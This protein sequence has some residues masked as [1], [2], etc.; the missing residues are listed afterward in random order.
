MNG[1][2]LYSFWFVLSTIKC[3]DPLTLSWHTRNLIC[4]RV[5][6]DRETK[7]QQQK[8]ELLQMRER[9]GSKRKEE[10][11]IKFQ[12][13]AVPQHTNKTNYTHRYTHTHTRARRMKKR[14]IEK[15]VYVR[16]VGRVVGSYSTTVISEWLH[17]EPKNIQT[18]V[19]EEK[20]HTHNNNIRNDVDNYDKNNSKI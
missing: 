1:Y 9:E 2:S 13:P 11:K 19:E 12:I 7:Q 10:K 8:Q 14:E 5:L 17:V 3:L 4:M 16:F 20:K 15:I 18:K 6:F